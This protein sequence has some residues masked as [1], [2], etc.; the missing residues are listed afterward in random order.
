MIEKRSSGGDKNYHD[1]NVCDVVMTAFSPAG[2]GGEL[3]APLRLLLHP[4]HDARQKGWP[5]AIQIVNACTFSGLGYAQ[6]GSG[7]RFHWQTIC[8]FP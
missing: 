6:T 3:K 2:I 5:V 7:W 8:V 4:C 1:R